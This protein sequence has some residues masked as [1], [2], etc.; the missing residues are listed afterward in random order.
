MAEGFC[1]EDLQSMV[2]LSFKCVL[3]SEA[4]EALQANTLQA[5]LSVQF[6]GI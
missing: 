5:A 4:A 3:L 1:K 6:W 2:R